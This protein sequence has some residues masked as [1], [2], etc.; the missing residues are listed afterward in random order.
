MGLKALVRRWFEEWSQERTE[1]EF[2]SRVDARIQ[3]WENEHLKQQLD[4]YFD[5]RFSARLDTL[6]QARV[7]NRI[8][9]RIDRRIAQ[10]HLKTRT[11]LTEDAQPPSDDA[12]PSLP[13]SGPA[14]VELAETLVTA[15]ELASLLGKSSIGKKYV[16]TLLKGKEADRSGRTYK[17][18]LG[19]AAALILLRS[20]RDR[21]RR[22]AHG[23]PGGQ[24]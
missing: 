12:T 16:Q 9:D 14:E 11:R 17:Y 10:W 8:D 2:Q 21:R 22:R 7:A 1:W 4:A 13:P 24:D 18:R 15:H 23:D 19:E 5:S 3:A 20:R 6:V